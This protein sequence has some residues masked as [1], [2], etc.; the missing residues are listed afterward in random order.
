MIPTIHDAREVKLTED[1]YFDDF[2]NGPYGVQRTTLDFVSNDPRCIE[3]I[4]LGKTSFIIGEHIYEGYITDV[5][6]TPPPTYAFP[7]PGD[8]YVKASHLKVRAQLTK[9]PIKIEHKIEPVNVKLDIKFDA[10]AFARVT[11]ALI[12]AWPPPSSIVSAI[13]AA[14][15]RAERIAKTEMYRAQM[16]GSFAPPVKPLMGGYVQVRPPKRYLGMDWSKSSLLHDYFYKS[17]E[18]TNLINREY[19]EK[20]TKKEKPV[21]IRNRFYVAAEKV[22]SASEQD[23]VNDP[24][25][26]HLADGMKRT[27]LQQSGKWTRPTLKAAIA[28]AEQILEANP[29]Q[30]HVA[31]VQ[32]VRTVRRKKAPLVVETVK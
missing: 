17:R 8:C 9:A 20:F 14:G 3:M 27:P 1:R 29:T 24:T 32:I 26:V 2:S 16:M 5:F 12:K 22:T 7:P 11:E 19:D 6:A 21:K 28:H 23:Q 25:K 13:V 15:E 30:D 10:A 31:I 4:R 18:F